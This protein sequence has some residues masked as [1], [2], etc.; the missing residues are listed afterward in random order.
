MQPRSITRTFGAILAGLLAVGAA[1]PAF[2]SAPAYLAL[3]APRG[4]RA[5]YRAETSPLGLDEVLAALA[6]DG[7]LG[8]P[9]GAWQPRREAPQDAFGTA[10]RYNRWALARLYGAVQ[11]RVAR[12]PRLV[13][14]RTAEAWILISPYP[15]PTFTR[16]EPGTL[17]IIV[18]SPGPD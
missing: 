13:D 6:D 14:G 1:Q 10:G 5:S 3:F 7:A 17:R 12:G 16:L 11:P 2:V 9:P 15:D 8:R 4:G 18:G